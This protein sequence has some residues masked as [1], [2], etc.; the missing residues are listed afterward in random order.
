MANPQK[1]KGDN[2]ERELAAYI[3]EYL[4]RELCSRAPLS[5]GG[6]VGI[7]SGGADLIGPPDLFIEAKRV[8]KLS[9]PAAMAQ[10]ERNIIQTQTQDMGVV[11]N[12]RNRM[13]T[14]QS[15]VLLRLDN[16]LRLYKSHLT[17]EGIL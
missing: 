15:Y 6:V 2:F 8:E 5:G 11:I 10:A 17:L 3:N 16:F 7:L 4:G 13:S 12:R 1:A 9:F 14:G